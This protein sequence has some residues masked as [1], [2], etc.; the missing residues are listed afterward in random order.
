MNTRLNLRRGAAILTCAASLAAAAAFVAPVASAAAP[1][2]S[3][4]GSKTIKVTAMG[5][6]AS[7]V[8][9]SRIRVEGGATCAE[10]YAVIRGAVL[11]E[12]PTGW[13]LHRG[14]FEVPHGLTPQIAEKGQ[15]KVK[16]ALVG[17]TS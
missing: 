6:A 8:A 16:Y 3:S 17:G 7:N 4:C 5:G 14:N 10:A 1:A 2:A 9:V 11:K 15:K 13:T 12:L